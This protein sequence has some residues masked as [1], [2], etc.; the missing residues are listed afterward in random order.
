MTHALSDHF[1]DPVVALLS[2]DLDQGPMIT[3]DTAQQIINLMQIDIGELMVMLLGTAA[4]YAHAP[5]SNYHVGTVALG[6][7]P[8]NLYLGANMEFPGQALLFSVHGEQSAMNHAWLSGQTGLQSIAIN[9][10]PCGYCR[11]FLYE[12][13][14]ATQGLRILLKANADPA[15]FTY[16]S[17]PLPE[18]LPDAFGPGDLNITDRLMQPTQHPL[19]FSPPDPLAAAAVNAAQHSYAPYTGNYS[20]VALLRSDGKIH[21]GR[22]AENA[23][24]NP[25]M[26]PIESALAWM[27]LHSDLSSGFDI[28]EAVLVEAKDTTI[29]QQGATAAVLSSVA[30]GIA[31]RHFAV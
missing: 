23:A 4:A 29:S 26:S 14:M 18:L 12:T 5:I 19:S 21:A 6:V 1:P 28:T 9:A 15:D 31:L 3:A 22:Y 30:P 10:A 11:Q 7:N 17:Q 27:A 8:G 13:S 20:G 24:F 16:S 25:S 2:A